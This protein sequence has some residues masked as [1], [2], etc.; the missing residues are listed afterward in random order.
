MT[1][2]EIYEEVLSVIKNNPGQTRKEINACLTSNYSRVA[3]VIRDLLITG[4]V[5]R[6]KDMRANKIGILK[7]VDIFY[8]VQKN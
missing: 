7:P 8:A 1:R 3:D 2:P 6:K 4:R 5:I